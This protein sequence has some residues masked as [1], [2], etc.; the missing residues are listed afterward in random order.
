MKALTLYELSA[1]YLHAL[2]VMTTPEMDVPMQAIADT[3]EGIEGQF[4]D[5]AVNVAKF[6]R[7]MESMA[8][9]IK[10]AEEKMSQRRRALESRAKWLRDYLKANMEKAS[11]TRIESPWFVLSI[12][13]NPA[14]LKIVDEAAIP[15]F[16]K[17]E[18][19][20]FEL[21][22]ASIK[23]TLEA[24]EEVPGAVLS[25]GTRLVVR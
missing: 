9:A 4:Q 8:E 21:D 25:Q 15:P 18:V 12:Q 1:E 19:I 13:K 2:E 22:K 16:F 11:V 17:T 23:Q 3:L 10:E 7:N 6:L 14:A 24:G 5:K 20:T